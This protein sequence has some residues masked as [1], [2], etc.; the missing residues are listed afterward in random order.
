M[1]HIC[2]A[3]LTVKDIGRRLYDGEKKLL[4]VVSPFFIHI[5]RLIMT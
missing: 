2:G 3:Q 4:M 5:P 1:P